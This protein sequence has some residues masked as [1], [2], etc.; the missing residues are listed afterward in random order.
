MTKSGSFSKGVFVEPE[1]NTAVM[2]WNTETPTDEGNRVRQRDDWAL[3]VIATLPW[4][5]NPTL[6]HDKTYGQFLLTGVMC[7]ESLKHWNDYGSPDSCT[8]MDASSL[9]C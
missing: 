2:G 7:T 4:D 6:G 8:S 1:V 3:Q 5:A 9:I